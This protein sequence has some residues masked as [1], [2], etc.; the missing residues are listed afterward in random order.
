M[1]RSNLILAV[2][3]ALVLS[4]VT[5]LCQW[6]PRGCEAVASVVRQQTNGAYEWKREPFHEGCVYLWRNGVQVGGYCYTDGNYRNYVDGV[7]SAPAVAPIRPPLE[8][9]GGLGT[10]TPLGVVA[11]KIGKEERLWCGD[12]LVTPGEAISMLT[13]GVPSDHNLPSLTV[14][15]RDKA[16]AKEARQLWDTSNAFAA[17]RGKVRFQAYDFS[18]PI[19]Q[20][21]LK[22]LGLESN[23]QFQASGVTVLAQGKTDPKTG[24]AEVKK[25]AYGFSEETVIDA[26]RPLVPEVAPKLPTLP[27][28]PEMPEIPADTWLILAGVGV[29]I[30]LALK[31]RK[32]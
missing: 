9:M 16:K 4:P 26:L 8:G 1:R 22:P 21:M 29:L 14:V 23:Q 28:W 3:A 10:G 30:V 32:P 19:N 11:E 18:N 20:E 25:Q 15:A 2:F 7:W 5:G 31:N 24:K 27:V 6:G 17:A 12:Y 13:E